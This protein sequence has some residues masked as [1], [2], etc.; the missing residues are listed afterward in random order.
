MWLALLG[1]ALATVYYKYQTRLLFT[2]LQSME[3]ELDDCEILWG[4]LQLELT[5]L[6]DQKRIEHVAS[7]QLMLV[8]PL[9]DKIIYVQ[10]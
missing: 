9:R 7:E 8:M 1:S 2:Q 5:T 10:P 3:R 4:Q 6:T